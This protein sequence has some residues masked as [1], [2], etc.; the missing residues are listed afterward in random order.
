MLCANGRQN[1]SEDRASQAYQGT[2]AQTQAVATFT[3]SATVTLLSPT[4]QAA[5]IVTHSTAR[6]ARHW[7]CHT[8]LLLQLELASNVELVPTS[9]SE[10]CALQDR[11]SPES[12]SASTPSRSPF[13]LPAQ[14]AS[15]HTLPISNFEQR[16]LTLSL[17]FNWAL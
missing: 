1:A 3:I 5:V 4:Q 17:L 10:Y 13:A 12:M 11:V 7:Q 2:Q 14:A 8:Y 6:S 16:Q 15:A 9:N